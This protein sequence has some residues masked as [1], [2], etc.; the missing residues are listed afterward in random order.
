MTTL[1]ELQV[2]HN[3]ARSSLRAAL[4]ATHLGDTVGNLYSARGPSNVLFLLKS[5]LITI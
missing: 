2:L 4:Q 1:N 5:V 3:K